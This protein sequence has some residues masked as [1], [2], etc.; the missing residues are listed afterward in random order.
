MVQDASRPEADKAEALGSSYR[1][2]GTKDTSRCIVDA[3]GDDD[4]C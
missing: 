4:A 1:A 3:D 2:A